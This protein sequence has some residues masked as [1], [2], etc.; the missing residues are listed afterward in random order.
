[1]PAN[2]RICRPVGAVRGRIAAGDFGGNFLPRTEA[3]IDQIAVR[4]LRKERR[5]VIEMLTLAAHRLF[6]FE[7]QPGQILKDPGLKFR[8]ASGHVDIL[9]PKQEMAAALTRR[10]KGR[11]RRVNMPK[12]QISRWTRREAGYSYHIVNRGPDVKIYSQYI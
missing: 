4:K 10:A 11:G 3:G 2:P 9:D 1:M 5:I 8:P 7:P 6:P 12:M